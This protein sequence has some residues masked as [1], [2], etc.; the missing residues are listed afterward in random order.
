MDMCSATSSVTRC[1]MKCE[2]GWYQITQWYMRR[3]MSLISQ[4]MCTT[5]MPSYENTRWFHVRLKPT[6]RVPEQSGCINDTYDLNVLHVTI[7]KLHQM[8][9]FCV[10]VL[11]GQCL[12]PLCTTSVPR[13]CTFTTHADQIWICPNNA[14]YAHMC[15]NCDM[16]LCKYVLRVWCL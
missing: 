14:A 10:F 9:V 7:Y 4:Q 5:S 8:C 3:V 15:P 2:R 11:R 12:E 16:Q 6:K 13:Y 1:Y